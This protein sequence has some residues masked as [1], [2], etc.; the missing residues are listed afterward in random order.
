MAVEWWVFLLLRT[1][2]LADSFEEKDGKYLLQVKDQA[3]GRVH[4]GCG[5]HGT[6]KDRNLL[7]EKPEIKFEVEVKDDDPSKEFFEVD[8]LKVDSLDLGDGTAKY[9]PQVFK[10][11]HECEHEHDI[12]SRRSATENG[13]WYPTRLLDLSAFP[14]DSKTIKLILSAE[15]ELHGSYLT[16]SHRWGLN[17]VFAL[18]AENQDLLMKSISLDQLPKTFVDAIEVTRKLGSR[19]LWIDSLCILQ[20]GERSK[21][22]WEHESSLMHEVYNHAHCNIASTAASDPTVGLFFDRPHVPAPSR[23]T[24]KWSGDHDD[25]R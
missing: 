15:T 3:G 6:E 24:V 1:V 22:D 25:L 5:S 14:K 8:S 12:C 19:Y 21:E 7:K 16:L 10:W 4:D 20:S 23:I 11:I 18:T 13:E 2:E 17:P 9:W